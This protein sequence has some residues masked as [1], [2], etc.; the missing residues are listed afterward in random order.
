MK[1]GW[2]KR[3]NVCP[4]LRLKRKGGGWHR[5]DTKSQWNS[6]GDERTV[7]SRLH[8]GQTEKKKGVSKGGNIRGASA[9]GVGGID[10]EKLKKNV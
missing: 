9:L 1:T 7:V 10:T 5:L 4:T 3:R 8:P 2:E 6:E